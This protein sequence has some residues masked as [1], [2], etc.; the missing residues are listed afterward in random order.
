[1]IKA[2]QLGFDGADVYEL[3][4]HNFIG[5]QITAYAGQYPDYVARLFNKGTANFSPVKAHTHIRGKNTFIL[6][7]IFGIFLIKILAI[8]FYDNANM[9]VGE[10]KKALKLERKT[11]L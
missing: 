3:R 9:Q 11:A 4:R 5:N 8:C 6:I 7:V 1:M 2:L 10:L